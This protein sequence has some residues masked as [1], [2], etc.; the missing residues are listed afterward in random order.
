MKNPMASHTELIE[1]A[2]RWLISNGHLCVISEMSGGYGEEADAIGWKP[3]LST[4]IEVKATRQ[5]FLADRAKFFRRHPE[6]GMG[7]YRYYL[8]NKGIITTEDLPPGWGWIELRK[9]RTWTRLHPFAFK[10]YNSRAEIALLLS[11]L[12]RPEGLAVKKYT[13]QTGCRAT[14]GIDIQHRL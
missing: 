6:Q 12:R 4:I 9:N 13:Y 3:H 5:D 14:L 8:C 11:A 7:M 10:N 2:K 1:K